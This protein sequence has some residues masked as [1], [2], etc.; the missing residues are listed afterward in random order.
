MSFYDKQFIACCYHKRWRVRGAPLFWI[1]QIQDV[2]E[3]MLRV[4]WLE[5]E[6]VATR[7]YTYEWN[8]ETDSPS[9]DLIYPS[10]VI[11]TLED[12]EELNLQLDE[13]HF[14]ELQAL[15]RDFDEQNKNT[16]C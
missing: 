9:T 13:S 10:S 15:A 11:A 12:F 2:C 1:G 16:L 7:R 3:K 14:H 8:D 4:T 6:D 5:L